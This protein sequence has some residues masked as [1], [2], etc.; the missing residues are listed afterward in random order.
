M[1]FW[2]CQLLLADDN[3]SDYESELGSDVESESDDENDN[4][5]PENYSGEEMMTYSNI[6]Q[7]LDS[8]FL[9]LVKF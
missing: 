4:V 6:I 8:I 9:S 3:K 5:F 7:T 2:F 1:L